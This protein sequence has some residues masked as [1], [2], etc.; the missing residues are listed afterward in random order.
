MNQLQVRYENVDNVNAFLKDLPDPYLV[1]KGDITLSSEERTSLRYIRNNLDTLMLRAIYRNEK[2]NYS[3]AKKENEW[4]QLTDTEEKIEVMKVRCKGISIQL[5]DVPIRAMDD[6]YQQSRKFSEFPSA[7]SLLKSWN[8][9]RGDYTQSEK[10]TI[11]GFLD[12]PENVHTDQDRDD[13]LSAKD[14]MFEEL[15]K[16]GIYSRK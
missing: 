2:I 10:K 16:A 7:T 11:R 14:E 15:I 13:S 3:L 12:K 1:R 9:I 5:G 8:A 6:I 4:L